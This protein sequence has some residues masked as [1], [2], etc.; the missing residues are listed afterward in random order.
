M[1]EQLDGFFHLREDWH[2]PGYLHLD[3]LRPSLAC[4]LVPKAPRDLEGFLCD[5]ETRLLLR[6]Q[7]LVLHRHDAVR[8]CLLTHLLFGPP[9]NIF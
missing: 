8:M 3:L 1:V 2:N 6:T 9:Q 4:N 5:H 7:G